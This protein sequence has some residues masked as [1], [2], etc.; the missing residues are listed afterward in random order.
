MRGGAVDGSGGSLMAS[1]YSTAGTASRLTLVNITITACAL[2]SAPILARALGPSG[3]GDLAAILVPIGLAPPLLEL[4]LGVYAGR[5]AAR[6]RSVATLKGTL[7]PLL[8]GLSLLGPL[9][10]LPVAHLLGEG[11]ETVETWLIVGM[12]LMPVA[13]MVNLFA[14]IAMGLQS[15]RMVIAVRLIPPVG[16]LA[17]LV[18]LYLADRLTVEAA[19]AVAVVTGTAAIIPLLPLI[20]GGGRPRFRR[21]VAKR[22]VPFGLKVWASSIAQTANVR[23]DQL[24]M[25]TLVE[26]RVLGLYAVAVT[27]AALPS[28]LIRGLSA[29]IFPRIASGEGQLAPR[30]LRITFL[31]ATVATAGMAVICEP[32][33]TTL[34]GSAFGDAT[35]MALILLVACLLQAGANMLDVMVTADG[36]PGASAVSQGLA[37]AITI[38]GLLIMLPLLGGEGAALVSVAAYGTTFVYL[39]VVARRRFGGRVRDYLVPTAEDRRI[40]IEA[41]RSA[42]GAATK[43]LRARPTAA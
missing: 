16:S 22:A 7:A 33:L 23:L 4:G 13:L 26:P 27:F 17:L 8:L 10:A 14:G 30:A 11:R 19:A 41:A 5:A 29:A 38:P 39:F 15:W 18:P 28:V 3:R 20:L 31:L 9:L 12:C 34:L 25:I 2:V 6:G 1:R 37:L 35:P 32:L 42:W 21:A 40:L 43:R 36:A 24:L